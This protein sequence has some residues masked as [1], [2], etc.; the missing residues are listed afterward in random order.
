MTTQNQQKK[1]PD[2][3][4]ENILQESLAK[5]REKPFNNTFGNIWKPFWWCKIVLESKEALKSIRAL[6]KLISAIID[7]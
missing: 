1:A 3:E 7:K 6:I 4:I 2:S 5:T